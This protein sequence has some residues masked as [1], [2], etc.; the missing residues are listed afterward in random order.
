MNKRDAINE[1]LMALNELPLQHSDSVEAIPTAILVDREINIAKKKVLS[2][3]W[4]F[5]TFTLSFYPNSE[6]H[7]VVP[8]TF[9]SADGGEDNPQVI[10]RDW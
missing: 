5:N 3:G 1:V 2:Y 4:E 7:I 10:I 8:S 9:L 6:G